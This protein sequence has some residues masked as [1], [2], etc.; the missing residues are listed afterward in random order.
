VA[1]A[2]HVI[3]WLLSGVKFCVE[4]C[5]EFCRWNYCVKFCVKFDCVIPRE[6]PREI[7]RLLRDSLLMWLLSGYGVA[8]KG[9]LSGYCEDIGRLLRDSL[10][11]GY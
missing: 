11:S 1:I 5:V 7:L 8:I 4:F 6:S 3:E 9:L 2:G 10:L